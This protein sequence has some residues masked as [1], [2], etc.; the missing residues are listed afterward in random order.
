MSKRSIFCLLAAVAISIAASSLVQASTIYVQ[1]TPLGATMIPGLVGS[2]VIDFESP[3]PGTY[4]TLTLSGVTFTPDSGNLMWVDAA[5]AGNY[6]TWGQSLHNNYDPQSFNVLTI[7]FNG[8]T[9]GFGFFWGASDTAWTLTAYDSSS[10]PIES[11]VLPITG[12]SNA[13]DFVGL[14]DPG[15]AWATLAGTG[16]DYIFV[17]NF[18]FN[19]TG[20][21]IPE[22]G[23]LFLLGSGIV[24][25]AGVFRRKLGL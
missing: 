13:G 25:I 12:P 24:G 6:N 1:T 4:T 11:Y 5:Y 15:I 9:T 8:I 19:P 2:T 20:S 14:L 23:S 18:E 7:N 21:T 3:A 10:N 22:P 16:S 17:D